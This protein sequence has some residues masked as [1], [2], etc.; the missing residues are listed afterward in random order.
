MFGETVRSPGKLCIVNFILRQA[1]KNTI[2]CLRIGQWSGEQV[3]I[4]A[5]SVVVIFPHGHP[6]KMF[7]LIGSE[8]KAAVSAMPLTFSSV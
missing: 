8:V 2:F 5:A 3:Y 7:G 6:K 1:L 4:N